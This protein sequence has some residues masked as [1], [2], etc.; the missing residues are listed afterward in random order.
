MIAFL[1]SASPR[2]GLAVQDEARLEAEIILF[3]HQLNVLRRRVPSN[4]KLAVAD[5]LVFVW[6]YRLFPS[7]SLRHGTLFGARKAADAPRPAANRSAIGG[8]PRGSFTAERTQH[9]GGK[10]ALLGHSA[11]LRKM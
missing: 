10:A 9:D 11:K 6:L 8:Q 5:R 2:R 1:E 4:P 3:R 7:A